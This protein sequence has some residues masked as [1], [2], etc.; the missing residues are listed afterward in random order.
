MFP[1]DAAARSIALDAAIDGRAREILSS[2]FLDD[3]LVQ[4]LAMPTIVLAE[5]NADHLGG[6]A[7]LHDDRSCDS[8][9]DASRCVYLM[10]STSDSTTRPSRTISSRIGRYARIF[11]SSSTTD[12]MIGRSLDRL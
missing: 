9:L 5:V 6:A 3:G 12:S 2:R 4:R 8:T 1:V 11:A 7:Q 10:T